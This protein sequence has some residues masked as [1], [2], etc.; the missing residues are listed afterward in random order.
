MQRISSE[1]SV[2]GCNELEIG[3]HH[4][5]DHRWLYIRAKNDGNKGQLIMFF[6]SREDQDAVVQQLYTEL[7]KLQPKF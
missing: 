6:S 1:T 7:G 3:L 2:Y 5:D 4:S